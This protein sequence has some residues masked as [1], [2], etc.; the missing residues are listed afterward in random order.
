[1][2]KVL[3]VGVLA[4]ALLLVLTQAAWAKGPPQK[5]TISGEGLAQEIVIT[6]DETTL[7]ALAMMALED[8]DTLTADA[9]E[10]MSGEGYLLTRFYEDSPDHFIPFDQVRYFRSPEGGRGYIQYIGIIGGSS[11][12]DG[13]WYR[14]TPEGE[15]ML[16]AVLVRQ[17]LKQDMV[18][19]A[20]M[21]RAFLN[22]AEMFAP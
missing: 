2:R 5:I 7:N 6:D 9:P 19:E 13:M 10:G 20:I 3:L 8:Y 1:M 11:E 14:P 16:Q 21:W 12:Y 17:E 18:Q 22:V 15:A 4:L